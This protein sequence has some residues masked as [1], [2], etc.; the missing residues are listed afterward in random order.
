MHVGNLWKSLSGLKTT[1][2][3]VHILDMACRKVEGTADLLNLFRHFAQ[4]SCVW[5]GHDDNLAAKLA[6]I[7]NDFPGQK[8]VCPI[9]M[10]I[11][12]KT[13]NGGKYRGMGS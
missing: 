5:E 9:N 13:L 2:N 4:A 11:V 12:K 7:L 8:A 6:L 1:L 10:N 3:L